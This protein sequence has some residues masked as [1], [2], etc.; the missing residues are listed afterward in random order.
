MSGVAVTLPA[1]LVDALAEAVL[2]RL[3]DRVD[4]GSP[5][6]DRPAAAA[7]LGMPV[8]RLEKDRTVP[9]HKWDG[10]VMYHRGELDEHLL[11]LGDRP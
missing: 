11:A 5:W 8:S 7:Y 2:E 4:A 1:E 6:M 9:S 10:R 3:A